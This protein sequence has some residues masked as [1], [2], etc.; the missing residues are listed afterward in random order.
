M[1]THIDARGHL[2]SQRESGIADG[3]R[4]TGEREHR[5]MCVDTCVHME[6]LHTG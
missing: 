2:A 6:E 4:R 1:A 5:A 3:F